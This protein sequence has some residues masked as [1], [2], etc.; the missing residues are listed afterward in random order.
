MV[1]ANAGIIG[2]FVERKVVAFYWELSLF[3]EDLSNVVPFITICYFVFKS[4][5]NV[6]VVPTFSCNS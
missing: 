3:L 1:M 4:P 6:C 2:T 5:A